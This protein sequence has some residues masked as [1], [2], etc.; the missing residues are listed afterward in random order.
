MVNQFPRILLLRFSNKSCMALGA[1]YLD[2]AAAA[3]QANAL[4]AGFAFYIFVGFALLK[5]LLLRG[6]KADHFG[7]YHNIFLVLGSSFVKIF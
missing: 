2:F 1:G 3:R 6:K 4:L 7:L 5:N